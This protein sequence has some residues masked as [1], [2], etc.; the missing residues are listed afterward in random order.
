MKSYII[1]LLLLI[2][3]VF[4]QNKNPEATIKE[5]KEFYNSVNDYSADIKIKIDL[6]VIKVPET[7]GKVYFK[8]PDKFK[9]ESEGFAL[10]PKQTLNFDPTDLLNFESDYV[11]VKEE[12]INNY[13][14]SHI[15]IIPKNDTVN[16]ISANIWIIKNSKQI[17]KLEINS[18]S[19]ITVLD[20]EYKQEKYPL[21]AS[22][23]FSLNNLN[24]DKK[25]PSDKK[26]KQNAPSFRT[27]E[28]KVVIRYSNYMI[29]KGIPD[30]IFAS[31]K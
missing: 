3:V 7:T 12:L 31:N 18:R 6:S 15:K 4:S 29:N 25:E 26:K 13:R 9:V 10:L 24:N 5:V 17:K 11:F 14:T 21:P 30:K 28:G 19:G 23:E 2:S 27:L 20:F 1:Y 22:I 8:K 16:V